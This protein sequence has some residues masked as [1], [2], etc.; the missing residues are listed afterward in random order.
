M[1]VFDRRGI[2]IVTEKIGISTDEV[3]KLFLGD[4]QVL[5]PF[6]YDPVTD[7]IILDVDLLE[8]MNRSHVEQVDQKQIQ[9]TPTK[10]E[11]L[12]LLEWIDGKQ[13]LD[14]FDRMHESLKGKIEAITLEE[15]DKARLAAQFQIHRIDDQT[16]KPTLDCSQDPRPNQI[17]DVRI[18]LAEDQPK[19]INFREFF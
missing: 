14:A 11:M 5:C 13:I 16:S 17:E 6:R 15:I 10:V 3:P 7:S 8:L 1:I 12:Q 9:I 2:V 19:K 4:T 18:G